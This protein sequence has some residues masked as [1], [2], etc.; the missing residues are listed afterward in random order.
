M[1][2]S[3]HSFQCL[4]LEQIWH[5]TAVWGQKVC[6]EKLKEEFL[7]RK[8]K[9]ITEMYLSRKQSLSCFPLPHPCWIRD[10]FFLPTQNKTLEWA[11]KTFMEHNYSINMSSIWGWSN[12]N[13]HDCLCSCRASLE[14]FLSFA[15]FQVVSMEKEMG[16]QTINFGGHK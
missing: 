3:G 5:Q 4:K 6:L 1:S 10:A 8:A 11:L 12:G 16:S 13:G 7:L 2:S 15:V 9:T 14:L